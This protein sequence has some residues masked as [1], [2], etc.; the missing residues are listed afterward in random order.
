MQITQESSSRVCRAIEATMRHVGASVEEMRAFALDRARL[1]SDNWPMLREVCNTNAVSTDLKRNVILQTMIRAFAARVL[2]LS[3][4]ATR[5]DGV[6]LAGTNKVSV[7]WFDLDTTA[8]HDFVAADGY[9]TFGNTSAGDKTIEVDQRKYQGL[10]WTSAEFA[11]QPFLDIAMSANLKAEQLGIDVVNDVLSLVKADP[12]G[13]PAKAEPAS[14]FDTDD[15]IDLKAAADAANWPELGRSL[16]LNGSYDVNLLKDVH[17]KAAHF[18]GDSTPIR[19]GRVRRILGFDYYPDSRIPAN[20]EFLQGFICTKSALLI[21]FS[22]VGPTAE[23]R[24]ALSRYELIVEP[25]T[26][27]QF[28]YRLWGDPNYDSS[29]EIIECNYGRLAGNPN[30]LLRITSQ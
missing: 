10:L 27:I 22:P 23:V 5:F 28:E 1:I 6:R 19:E 29:K 26:G 9:D 20:G 13:D 3:A 4:F 30:A 8:S 25:S 12:F 24:S 17:I 11:R 14:A 16:V 18:W 7:P 15:A 21:A 2:V